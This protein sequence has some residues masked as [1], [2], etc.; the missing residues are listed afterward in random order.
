MAPIRK[1]DG[2]PLEIPGVQEVRSGD[3]RVFFVDAIPDSEAL[4]AH[5][6]MQEQPESDSETIDTLIDQSGNGNDAQAVGSPTMDDD[7]FNGLPTAI[8]DGVDDAWNRDPSDFETLEQPFSAYAVVEMDGSLSSNNPIW[9]DR[10]VDHNIMRWDGSN[11]MLYADSSLDG[12]SDSDANRI[13]GIFDGSD[14]L[15]DV[16]GT[17]DTGN[18]STND[19]GGLSIGRRDNEED[20]FDGRFCELLLYDTKHDS[21][22]R[23]DVHDYLDNRWGL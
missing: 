13:T 14:S 19:L 22:T 5:F 23:S 2:A 16:D 6:D 21:A 12:A 10:R 4:H 1:G 17:T 15:I 3:G 8:L 11:W 20:F 18:P 7:G 9:D